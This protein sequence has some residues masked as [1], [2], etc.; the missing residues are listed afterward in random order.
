MS[1]GASRRRTWAGVAFILG[2][3]ATIQ[4]SAAIVQPVFALVG[5][6]SASAWRFLAGAIALVVASR[7]RPWRFTR[8]QWRGAAALGFSVAFMNLCFYQSI[9]RIPLGSAVAIEYLGPFLVAALSRRSARHA[10]L[11]VLAGVGVLFL[12]RP[13]GG[14]TLL[15][16]VFALGSGAGWAAYAFASHHVGGLSE[17]F[18]G[19]AVAMSVAAVVTLPFALGRTGALVA[20]PVDAGRLA[21]VGVMAIAIGF[22]FEMQAL[23]RIRPGIVS[24]LLAL[25][26]AVAF[27]IGWL[28]LGQTITPYDLVGLVCV[29][30]AGVGVTLDVAG[31]ERVPL[32]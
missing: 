26:P 8:A 4:W 2:G 32:Q 14:I 3:A 11:V 20:H 23:R 21:L 28:F 27:L 7:P 25:D 24:V 9:A 1:A 15:G 6:S 22:A 31:E 16:A 12:A 10:A 5:P 19:L 29:V 17:G 30:G 18:D 13:G